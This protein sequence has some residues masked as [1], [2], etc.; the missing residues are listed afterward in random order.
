MG[1]GE[2]VEVLKQKRRGTLTEPL[3]LRDAAESCASV[4]TIGS[5][6]EHLALILRQLCEI[7]AI[8]VV[9]VIQK[10]GC[11]SESCD[12]CSTKPGDSLQL[13]ERNVSVVCKPRLRLIPSKLSQ[14]TL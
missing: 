9:A 3:L 1:S 6:S 5:L 11:H 14:Y 12:L 10:L 13:T 8:L 7:E 4:S 2:E